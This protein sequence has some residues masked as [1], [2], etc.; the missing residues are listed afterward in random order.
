MHGVL[1]RVLLNSAIV[2]TSQ[3]VSDIRHTDKLSDNDTP[4]LTDGPL[5]ALNHAPFARITW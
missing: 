3:I 2:L 5:S 4:R 1:G